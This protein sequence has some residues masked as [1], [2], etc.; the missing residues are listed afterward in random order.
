MTFSHSLLWHFRISCCGIFAFARSRRCS[1]DYPV[2]H[3][4]LCATLCLVRVCDVRGE[5]AFRSMMWSKTFLNTWRRLDKYKY[6]IDSTCTFPEN[7]MAFW[8]LLQTTKALCDIS[9]ILST[10]NSSGVW[11]KIGELMGPLWYLERY[12]NGRAEKS[13]KKN[14]KS[15]S[16]TDNPRR[17]RWVLASDMQLLKEHA[18]FVQRSTESSYLDAFQQVNIELLNA[19]YDDLKDV[20]F[21]T[22]GSIKENS[23]PMKQFVKLEPLLKEEKKLQE[24]EMVMKTEKPDEHDDDMSDEH[25]DSEDEDEDQVDDEGEDESDNDSS[26][27]DEP[28]ETPPTKLRKSSSSRMQSKCSSTEKTSKKTHPRKRSAKKQKSGGKDKKYEILT[29]LD[30]KGMPSYHLALMVTVRVC[31]RSACDDETETVLSDV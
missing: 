4:F 13:L 9:K 16:K 17:S 27:D 1:V 22:S 28:P 7:T 20:D 18:L 12:I 26:D 11:S 24:Q 3:S 30:R 8:Q 25:D 14:T 6:Q 19:I 29:I 2:G 5:S 10:W 31:A 21:D 23:E 15:K